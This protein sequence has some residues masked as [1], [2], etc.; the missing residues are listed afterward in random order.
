MTASPGVTEN[1]PFHRGDYLQG[2]TRLGTIHPHR[3]EGIALLSRPVPDTPYR[4]G[5]SPWPYLWVSS[6]RQLSALHN[7]YR[8]LLTITVI[9]QPG[10]RPP[11]GSVEAFL[12]KEHYVFD[13]TLPE[14]PLSARSRKRLDRCRK[15]AV[16]E[17]VIDHDQRLQID[18]LYG[19]LLERR[20]L[21][22][23]FFDMGRDHF[24][25]ID[26]LP[27]SLFMQVRSGHQ[28][29]AM[30]CGVRFGNWLQILHTVP[31]H[32]GLRWDASYLL[33]SGLQEIARRENRLM[34]L[35]GLPATSSAG[36]RTFKERWTNRMEPVYL[37]RI[38]NDDD[39]YRKLCRARQADTTGGYFPGYRE[40]P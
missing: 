39:T 5:I 38:V 28:I 31:T 27:G 29:G 24:E 9:C 30:A 16:I 4:D 8:D 10:Y 32:E 25:A 14:R 17:E 18:P 3:N 35:G 33:M 11:P 15:L 12:F 34:F 21:R 2:L 26:R 37:L 1:S 6:H 20:Q 23:G 7:D 22:G 36:L 40:G 19:A 13:P